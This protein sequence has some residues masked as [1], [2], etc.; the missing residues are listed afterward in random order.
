[1]TGRNSISLLDERKAHPSD[2]RIVPTA[3]DPMTAPGEAD[4]FLLALAR[5]TRMFVGNAFALALCRPVAG[6]R[7]GFACK[8]WRFPGTPRVFGAKRV[9]HLSTALFHV[10]ADAGRFRR[11]ESMF[12]A[13]WGFVLDDVRTEKVPRPPALAPTFIVETRPGSQQWGYA[14]RRPCEDKALLRAYAKGLARSGLT[15]PGATGLHRLARLPGARPPGKQR[16]RLVAWTGATY[17]VEELPE[18]LG[19][20]PAPIRRGGV[21]APVAFAPD[22]IVDPIWDLLVEMNLVAEAPND[23]GWSPV[24][25]PRHHEHSDPAR[26]WARYRPA[27]LDDGAWFKCFHSH[28]DQYCVTAFRQDVKQI[29]SRGRAA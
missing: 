6:E 21:S 8:P 7:D 14:F 22:R 5:A 1:M 18:R 23:E 11:T 13:A 10:P 25:C 15:D 16:A 12:A 27:T 28:G 17:A 2:D 29:A 20:E 9:P 19:F 24:V 4:V 26:I 3:V